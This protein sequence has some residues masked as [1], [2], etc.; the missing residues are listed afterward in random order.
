[1]S[2]SI[3]SSYK[4]FSEKF[5]AA[6]DEKRTAALK[7]YFQGGGVINAVKRGSAK[8]P[9]L[10]YPSQKRVD[11]QVR[12]IEKLRDDLSKK[13][14]E[15]KEKLSDAKSYHARHQI[16]KFSDPLYWQHT[17]KALSDKEYKKDAQTVGLPVHLVAD[18]KWKPMVKM[19]MDDLEYRK[20]L[21]ETVQTSIVYKKD[22]RV[23][24]YAD[25]IQGFRS[26]I[27]ASKLEEL[28]K[29]IAALE[30][31][32]GALSEIRKWAGE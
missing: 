2:S 24:K 19:F 29:R 22:R 32:I 26:E 6:G 4:S 16:M 20:N 9:K 18:K 27:S 3:I 28:R 14:K 23:A 10:I 13:E 11:E 5:P 1:M 21:V 25:D 8:W 7:F 12:E 15:W 31:Q 30:G 17:A